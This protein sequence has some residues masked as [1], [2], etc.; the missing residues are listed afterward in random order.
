M[1]FSPRY[2]MRAVFQRTGKKVT[3]LNCQRK[4]TYLTVITTE[5]AVDEKLIEEQAG[6]RKK[7][8]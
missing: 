4:G 5:A 8:K 2:G 1:D 6:F 7:E 3:S